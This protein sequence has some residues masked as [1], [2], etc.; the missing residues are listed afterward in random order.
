MKLAITGKG[1]VGKTTVAGAM[2]MLLARQGTTVLA[3]DADPDANL[4]AA[5][6]MSPEMQQSITPIAEHRAMI[7]ERTG[8]KVRQYGQIFKLNPEVSD[9]SDR[10]AVT[11]NGVAL[12]VL[13]A[14]ESGGSGC[15]CPENVIASS[16]IADLVL[17][18]NQSLVIDMEAGLEHLGRATAR[19]VDDM[20]IV[21]E[22]GQRAIDS[23]YRIIRMA[24]DI[25]VPSIKLVGNKVANDQDEHFIR[26]AFPDHR[27][28]GILPFDDGFRRSDREQL[29]VLENLSDEQV[30]RF[31]SVIQHVAGGGRDTAVGQT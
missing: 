27:L 12:L 30:A 1:G 3:L 21:V 25:G 2:S 22:P 6:G 9:L 19:R 16:L 14:I 23:A 20:I 7:E 18:K 4:A 17:Y 10:F 24:G 8:A 13:G 26:S 28:I 29:S 11:Y 15:A 5:L 31:N